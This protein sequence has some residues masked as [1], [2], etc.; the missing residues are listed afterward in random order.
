MK[1]VIITDDLGV[2]R[3]FE[4]AKY[5]DVYEALVAAIDSLIVWFESNDVYDEDDTA[6][7]IE[8]LEEIREDVITGEQ[9]IDE[10]IKVYGFEIK[11]I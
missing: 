4:I 3:M 5:N 7:S 9:D 11:C 6:T 1:H 2:M 10:L 8:Y